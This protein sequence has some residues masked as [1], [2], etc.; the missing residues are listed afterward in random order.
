MK[1]LDGLL[2]CFTHNVSFNDPDEFYQHCNEVPHKYSG[3]CK[4][5]DCGEMNVGIEVDEEI[6]SAKGQAR[7]KE[8]NAILEVNIAK[9]IAKR[10]AKNEGRK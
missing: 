1:G 6:K 7:C 8:C 4:C 10:N 9:R 3:S 2:K 5:D